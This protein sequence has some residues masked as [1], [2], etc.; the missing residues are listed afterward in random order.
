MDINEVESLLADKLSIIHEGKGHWAECI[1]AIEKYGNE[2]AAEAFEE[3]AKHHQDESDKNANPHG[4]WCCTQAEAGG[5]E[6]AHESD[7]DYCRD[8]ASAIRST[9]RGEGE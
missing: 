4:G 3:A 6:R 8:R 9:A 5:R 7:A 2:R 1:Q